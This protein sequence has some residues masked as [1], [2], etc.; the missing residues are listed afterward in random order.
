RARYFIDMQDGT[1]ALTIESTLENPFNLTTNHK[2]A[3]KASADKGH[4]KHQPCAILTPAFFSISTYET[5]S[6]PSAITSMLMVFTRAVMP[7]R[8][9]G[10]SVHENYK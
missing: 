10:I 7:E 4:E 1:H 3:V 8:I 2:K 5:V 9:S 6:T